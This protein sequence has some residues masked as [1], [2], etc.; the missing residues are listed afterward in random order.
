MRR[1]IAAI[2]VLF[3]S[4][5][6]WQ[7]VVTPTHAQDV[8][9]TRTATFTRTPRPTRTPLPTRTP[10]PSATPRP[11]LTIKFSE[12][13]IKDIL[14]RTRR[15]P[16]QITGVQIDIIEG[17]MLLHMEMPTGLVSAHLI[18]S[19][20]NGVVQLTTVAMSYGGG[21]PVPLDQYSHEA[22]EQQKAFDQSITNVL[23]YLIQG[24]MRAG[25]KIQAAAFTKDELELTIVR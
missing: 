8:T 20:N 21:Q 11:P 6:I 13:E 23:K 15:D 2:G 9:P 1:L 7:S 4:L 25:Y 19:V 12:Q 22:Q 24:K 10:R 14:L 16:Q 17:Q 5:L 3:T 18:V